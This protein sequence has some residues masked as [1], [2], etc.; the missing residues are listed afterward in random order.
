M[1]ANNKS[2]GL[3]PIALALV[4][5][6]AVLAASADKLPTTADVENGA[7]V[8]PK[9][10][11]TLKNRM[12]VYADVSKTG[13]KTI[14]CG[15]PAPPTLSTML[16]KSSGAAALPPLPALPQLPLPPQPQVT[17][18]GNNKQTQQART[19][20]DCLRKPDPVNVYSYAQ[21]HQIQPQ[22]QYIQPQ[23]HVEP[24]QVHYVQ[25]PVAQLQYQPAVCHTALCQ[26]TE[27]LH[28]GYGGGGYYGRS[29]EY[30]D[31]P[32]TVMKSVETD[33]LVQA[34]EDV[35][36]QSGYAPATLY[37]NPAAQYS[38]GGPAMAAAAYGDDMLENT[39]K[40]FGGSRMMQF[41][42]MRPTPLFTPAMRNADGDLQY[43][44]NPVPV[45]S[46]PV[47]MMR[48]SDDQ[49]TDSNQR[50]GYIIRPVFGQQKLYSGL[51]RTS[52]VQEQQQLPLD[53]SVPESPA[54]NP[55]PAAEQDKIKDTQESSEGQ[56]LGDDVQ[57]TKSSDLQKDM[58]A[59][60]D[61]KKAGVDKAPRN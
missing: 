36:N 57:P 32:A 59:M 47:M 17:E 7:A 61:R 53:N 13:K 4:V 39:R 54:F 42:M 27:Q 58:K 48:V 55:V 56:E 25:K 34:G 60:A 16:A 9:R 14:V 50:Y 20:L 45:P 52:D 15:D 8:R 33:N 11:V 23:I 37:S 29:V 49:L 1:I 22:I 19:I 30:M 46:V 41:P 28:S 10:D 51:T 21:P 18:Q 35:L 3:A 31:Y 40:G 24:P 43:I 6:T 38:S 2:F 44:D 12:C 5:A 26:P